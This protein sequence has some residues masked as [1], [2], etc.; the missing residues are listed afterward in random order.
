[1]FFLIGGSHP[2]TL[3]RF[4]SVLRPKLSTKVGVFSPPMDKTHVTMS[5]GQLTPQQLSDLADEFRERLFKK[6]NMKDPIKVKS[7]DE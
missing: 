5:L 1:M 7:L 3:K 4:G 2:T 6:A